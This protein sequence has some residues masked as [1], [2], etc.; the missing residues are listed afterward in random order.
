ME[1]IHSPVLISIG[2]FARLAGVSIKALRLYA[3][4]GLLQ[5]ACISPQ[6]GYR[7]YEAS[8]LSQLHRILMLK[9]TGLSLAE[10]ASNLWRRDSSALS[11]VRETLALRA[12]EI[13][14]Q[15][16]WVEA[17]IRAAQSRDDAP[18][19]VIKRAPKVSVLSVRKNIDSY[20]QADEML[21]D[22]GR[23]VQASDRLVSG[24]IWHDCGAR[25]KTIDCEAFW[26]LNSIARA[27]AKTL[28]PVM[29]A[30]MMH[31]GDESTMPGSYE[32]ARRWIADHRF[33]VTGP[34]REIYLGGA[35]NGTL[36]EIQFPIERKN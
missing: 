9:N 3:R 12:E 14:R 2:K 13:Q 8:Q 6:S 24:A 29:V 22:L 1:P 36:T 21:R 18:K 7:R 16:S 25:T 11:K 28:A 34:N 17:E 20:D 19:I 23:R 35:G 27:A 10:I 30:S 26:I 31:E 5:P 32:I 15:L 33:K 4:L